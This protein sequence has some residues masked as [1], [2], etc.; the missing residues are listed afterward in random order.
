MN[1][2]ATNGTTERMVGTRRMRMYDAPRNACP[3]QTVSWAEPANSAMRRVYEMAGRHRPRRCGDACVQQ[4]PGY[5]GDLC[6][7]WLARLRGSQ[8]A[9]AWPWVNEPGVV[10]VARCPIA[11][12]P[13]RCSRGSLVARRSVF[14]TASRGL[15]GHADLCAERA[16]LCA[17]WID[18]QPPFSGRNPTCLHLPLMF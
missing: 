13:S 5:A 6:V 9:G 14:S 17:K 7:R 18:S 10:C 1:G 16:K 3:I 11:S 2:C 15:R 4:T 12:R 8:L